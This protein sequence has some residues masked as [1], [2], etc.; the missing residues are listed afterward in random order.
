VGAVLTDTPVKVALEYEAGARIKPVTHIRFFSDSQEKSRKYKQLKKMFEMLTRVKR[1]LN[2][3][4]LNARTLTQHLRPLQSD[5]SALHVIN[6]PTTVG[7]D[8]ATSV[9]VAT[10]TL[11]TTLTISRL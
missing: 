3:F 6:G 11:M 10:A 1:K 2:P 4:V 9:F 5:P 8:S 7:P